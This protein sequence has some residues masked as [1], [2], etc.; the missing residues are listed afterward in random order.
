M[1]VSKIIAGNVANGLFDCT[2][3]WISF[4]QFAKERFSFF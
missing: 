4:D 3:L 2:V 1:N